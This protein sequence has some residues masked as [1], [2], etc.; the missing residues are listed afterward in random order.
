M[1][2]QQRQSSFLFGGNAPYIEEQDELYLADPESVSDEWRG[3]RRTS[4]IADT[5]LI[6]VEQLYPFPSRQLAAEFARNPNL[7][8]AVWCQEEARNQGAWSFPEPLLRGIVGSHAQLRYAGPSA[9]A[10]TAAAYHSMHAT[11][12]ATLFLNA[13]AE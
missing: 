9:S 10:S 13:F 12:Q 7:K 5:P 3:Y 4:G 8:T 1:L 6:R 11:R 2:M